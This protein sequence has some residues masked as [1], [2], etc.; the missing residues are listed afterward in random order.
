MQP[1]VFHGGLERSWAGV[2]RLG[3]QTRRQRGA[4]ACLAPAEAAP[5]PA[6]CSGSTAPETAVPTRGS[7]Q[8]KSLLGSGVAASR[9]PMVPRRLLSDCGWPVRM[10]A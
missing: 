1:A 7:A 3:I 10:A 5:L 8:G 2:R 4:S 9:G 6:P